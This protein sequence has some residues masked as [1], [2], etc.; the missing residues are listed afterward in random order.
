MV[1]DLENANDPMTQ[2]RLND[3][4]LHLTCLQHISLSL[5][6]HLLLD[7]FEDVPLVQLEKTILLM[8][9]LLLVLVD[10]RHLLQHVSPVLVH[11]EL[12]LL[13]RFEEADI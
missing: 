7:N 13:L 1:E 8:E 9:L 6:E 2:R 4:L 11:L 3:P 10:F 12:N 5:H